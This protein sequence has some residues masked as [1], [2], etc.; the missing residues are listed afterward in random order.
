MPGL[1]VSQQATFFI[2]QCQIFA[3]QA[4]DNLIARFV[5]IFIFDLVLPGARCQQSGLVQQI[6]QVRTAESRR[7]TSNILQ[8]DILPQRFI[9][10]VDFKDLGPVVHCW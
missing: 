9:A 8:I 5:D 2:G 4:H 7:S 1:M 3:F 10:S 6:L